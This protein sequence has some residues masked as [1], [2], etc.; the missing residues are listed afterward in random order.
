MVRQVALILLILLIPS[1]AHP[2]GVDNCS[3]QNYNSE[4]PPN[5]G[6]PG[7]D[8]DL[9]VPVLS[10]PAS[11]PVARGTN[12]VAEWDGALVHRDSLL[13]VGSRLKAAR[14]LRWLD[15]LTFSERYAIEV[16]LVR[17]AA[18]IQHDHLEQ[19]NT[20]MRERVELLEQ[21][22]ARQG[23]WYRSWWFGVVVGVVGSVVFFGASLLAY[24]QLAS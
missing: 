24:L 3:T 17:R 8:E 9:F 14:R 21:D 1:T 4:A 12:V 5:F 13:L 23:A 20:L 11:V 10:P 19:R 6:C 15:R 18:E 22:R 7:P 16:E 2:Q